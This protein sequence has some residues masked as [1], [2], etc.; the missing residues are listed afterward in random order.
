MDSSSTEITGDWCASKMLNDSLL[1]VYDVY[2]TNSIDFKREHYSA[3]NRY[4]LLSR[5]SI[6]QTEQ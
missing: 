6:Q 1:V 5:W 2:S 3:F 4:H